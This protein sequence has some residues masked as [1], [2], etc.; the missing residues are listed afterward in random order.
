MCAQERSNASVLAAEFCSWVFLWLN[1]V[2]ER[3]LRFAE[4]S[5]DAKKRICQSIP[6]QSLV[7]CFDSLRTNLAVL[8]GLRNAGYL[9]HKEIKEEFNEIPTCFPLLCLRCSLHQLAL[10]RK[11]VLFQ[12]KGHWSAIV[13]L[14][15]LFETHGFRRQFQKSLVRV[16]S[17]SFKVVHVSSM[18]PEHHLWQ[19]I[20]NRASGLST[21]DPSYSLGRI[22]T[23]LTLFIHDNGDPDSQSVT[24]WCVGTCCKG[25]TADE[26]KRYALVQI[27]K[28][29]IKLFGTGFAV[30]LTYRW[31][32]AHPA[33]HFVTEGCL[34]HQILPRTL[35]QLSQGNVWDDDREKEV[36]DLLSSS[37][38]DVDLNNGLPSRETDDN[39][40]WE[41]LLLQLY[42]SGDL[43]P[44]EINQ[45]RK[46][47]TFQ[48]FRQPEFV[49]RTLLMEYLIGP[50]VQGMDDFLKRTG[51]IAEIHQLPLSEADKRAQLMA[52]TGMAKVQTCCIH[53]L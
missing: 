41:D 31:L 23:F 6:I 30:P 1:T 49:D 33:L 2:G 25:T 48:A 32:K 26:K 4:V 11:Q 27:V 18:P 17:T 19:Q 28:S 36:R 42:N 53:V 46:Q 29:Y 52:R 38:A 51:L 16:L 21:D 12:F 14:A 15:H 3:W 45:K 22:S 13:R 5:S 7:V 35:D 50:L 9:K 34:L 39:Q 47:L 43:S 24:H 20:R 10:C 37:G 8:K 44:A 40:A